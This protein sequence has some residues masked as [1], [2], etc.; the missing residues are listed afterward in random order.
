MSKSEHDVGST[1]KL[2]L[3]LDKLIPATHSF[4]EKIERGLCKNWKAT[5]ATVTQNPSKLSVP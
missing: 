2:L 3:H 1:I 4:Q 5:L